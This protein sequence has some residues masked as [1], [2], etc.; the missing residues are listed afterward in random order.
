MDDSYCPVIAVRA[1]GTRARVCDLNTDIDRE[2][3]IE[4][5]ITLVSQ[6][7]GVEKVLTKR[8]YLMWFAKTLGENLGVVH[9]R[10][11]RHN[12]LLPK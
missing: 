10:G 5:A 3:V 12:R 4:D 1:F 9:Q 11:W 8:E 2:T 6:E 7:L